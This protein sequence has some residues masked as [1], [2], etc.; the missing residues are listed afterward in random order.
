[1]LTRLQKTRILFLKDWKDTLK[2]GNGMILAVLPLF[3]TLLYRMLPIDGMPMPREFIS[4]IGVLMNLALVP[5]ALLSMM[6]AEEKEKNTLRTLMLSNVGAVEFL[7]SKCLVVLVLL[8]VVNLAVFFLTG[9]ALSAL[10][11]FLL[12]TTLTAAVPDVSGRGDRSALQEPDVHRHARLARGPASND[13]PDV[14]ANERH[15][16]EDRAVYTD[17]FHDRI[18]V[19]ERSAQGSSMDGDRRMAGRRVRAV[20]ACIPQKTVGRVNAALARNRLTIQTFYSGTRA[21]T[22]MRPAFSAAAAF[23]T[24]CASIKIDLIYVIIIILCIFLDIR[25]LN[26]YGIG[27]GLGDGCFGLWIWYSACRLAGGRG[28]CALCSHAFT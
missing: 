12:V 14:C 19:H 15:R 17:L 26:A 5:V 10:P 23:P 13:S 21:S 11:L 4:L 28:A 20:Y 25:H 22:A 7:T 2:N 9:M 3:F 24:C 18:A 27:R 6:I 1:M 16:G 8:S